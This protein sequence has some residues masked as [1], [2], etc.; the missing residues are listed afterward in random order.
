M[1]GTGPLIR[2]RALLY[3]YSVEQ[4]LGDSGMEEIM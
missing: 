2:G 1:A 4:L 3:I